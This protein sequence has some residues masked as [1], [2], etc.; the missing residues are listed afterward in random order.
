MKKKLANKNVKKYKT[1]YN[2]VVSFHKCP[3]I[4]NGEYLRYIYD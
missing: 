1:M 2:P 3:I 4:I